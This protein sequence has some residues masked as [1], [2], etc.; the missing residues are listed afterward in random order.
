MKMNGEK[1]IRVEDISFESEAFNIY[2]PFYTSESNMSSDERSGSDFSDD[3]SLN[4]SLSD[5]GSETNR[6]S[7]E[8]GYG[9]SYISSSEEERQRERDH[10][11]YSTAVV[12]AAKPLMQF[13]QPSM[14]IPG[15]Q[16]KFYFQSKPHAFINVGHMQTDSSLYK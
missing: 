8:E 2:Y 9:S 14:I 1:R 7:A 4:K 3:I 10:N 16:H 12:T 13:N 15:Q 6:S 5:Y 11:S